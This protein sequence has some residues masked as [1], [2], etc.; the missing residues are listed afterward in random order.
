[1][2]DRHAGNG[3]E[4]GGIIGTAR[5]HDLMRLD[6]LTLYLLRVPLSVPYKLSFG[7][8]EAFDTIIAEARAADGRTGLGEA[9]LLTGYTDETVDG[10]WRL[11]RELGAAIARRP[12]AAAQEAIALAMQANV[13]GQVLY[14][15]IE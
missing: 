11:A 15:S 12:L 9:T 7:P 3:A 14:Y 13:G 4:I 6:H 10:S 2:A 8:V 1:M 5:Q